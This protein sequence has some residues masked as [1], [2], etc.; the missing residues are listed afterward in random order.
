M[1]NAV[2]EALSIAVLNAFL[3]ANLIAVLTSCVAHS[4]VSAVAQPGAT[5]LTVS[6]GGIHQQPFIYNSAPL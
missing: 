3:K 1:L 6:G 5:H 2:L 4:E